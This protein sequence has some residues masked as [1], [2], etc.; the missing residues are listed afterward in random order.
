MGELD[1][2]IIGISWNYIAEIENVSWPIKELD[3]KKSNSQ[4][5]QMRNGMGKTTTTLLLR[6]LFSGILPTFDLHQSIFERSVY[7]G[8]GKSP[9]GKKI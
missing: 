3:F 6:H 2:K 7:A 9:L 4:I 1:C 5:I 8:G